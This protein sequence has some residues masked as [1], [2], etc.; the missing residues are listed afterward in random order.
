LL[1][2]PG[3]RSRS[4]PKLT[5]LAC[6]PTTIECT[7][8]ASPPSPSAVDGCY[9]GREVPLEYIH[10]PAHLSQP[11][12]LTQASSLPPLALLLLLSSPPSLA[13]PS[14]VV[15]C[16]KNRGKNKPSPQIPDAL[17]TTV[18]RVLSVRP[19][20]LPQ[21]PCSPVLY[22]RPQI[23]FVLHQRH[24][25]ATSTPL[26]SRFDHLAFAPPERPQPRFATPEN[27]FN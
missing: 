27:S 11:S 20:S 19:L 24:S 22:C 15:V 12:I 7:V 13:L 21:K 6:R 9:S 3:P 25:D 17:Y 4:P 16:K 2:A 5:S 18:L 14:C 10:H 8:A 26:P 23:P 1:V